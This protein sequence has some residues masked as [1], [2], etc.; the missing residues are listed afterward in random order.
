M[1]APAGVSLFSTILFF[2]F[3]LHSFFYFCY[4]HFFSPFASFFKGRVFIHSVE[5][6]SFF[7]YRVWNSPNNRV[8]PWTANRVTEFWRWT[9][10]FPSNITSSFDRFLAGYVSSD[11]LV[12]G[13]VLMA[14]RFD[15][16]SVTLYIVNFAKNREYETEWKANRIHSF[17]VSVTV[18][19]FV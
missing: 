17:C 16:I 8:V 13:S 2:L 19:C 18:F 10:K 1:T 9:A 14:S 5:F 3:F 7:L 6:S 12:S 4:Y 11:L 15:T